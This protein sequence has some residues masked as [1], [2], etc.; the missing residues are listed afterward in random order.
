MDMKQKRQL[1]I[2]TAESIRLILKKAFLFYIIL[3]RCAHHMC[4]LPSTHIYNPK[5]RNYDF[6]MNVKWNDSV[7]SS[8]FCYV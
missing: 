6:L 1:F 7:A 8:K 3:S 5:G 4:H 2:Q